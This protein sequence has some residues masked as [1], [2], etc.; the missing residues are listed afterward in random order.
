[1]KMRTYIYLFLFVLVA[2][3]AFWVTRDSGAD[4]PT[5]EAVEVKRGDVYHDVSVTGHIEPTTRMTLAFS[6]GGRL[7]NL[8][9][10]EG[11][12]VEKG[13]YIGTLDAAVSAYAVQEAEARLAVE[14]A[15]LRELLAPLRHEEK[16][17]KDASV[18]NA[19]LALEQ[20]ERTSRASLERAYV[21][22]D[23]A[24]H[25]KADELFEGKNANDPTLGVT[26]SYGSTKYFLKADSA[27]Q[28]ELNTKRKK[29]ETLLQDMK[30]RAGSTTVSVNESLLAT[31]RDLLYIQDFL[32]RLAEVVNNY[33][34]SDTSDQAVYE[35]YQASV[36][37]ARTAVSTVRGEVLVSHSA[38]ISAEATLSLALRDLELSVAGV[39]NE[40]VSAQEAMVDTARAGV[41]RASKQLGDTVLRA[42]RTGV[43]S[44]V[45]F[46]AGEIVSPYEPVAELITEGVYEV[47]AYIPEADIA[48]VKIG[49]LST[50]TFDAFERGD[51]FE[52]EVVRIAL[53]ETVKDGVPTY[54][55]TLRLTDSEMEGVQLRPG[56]TADIEIRTDIQEDVLFVP[57]RSVLRKGAQ[58]YVRVFVDGDF[59]E[60]YIET[61]LRGSEGT[62][63][64]IS[65][66]R[67]GEEIVL[68]VEE[69]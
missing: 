7:E 15:K 58:S 14:Q 43:V 20:A 42:P 32:S 51:M 26:F 50:I 56:M 52:G 5:F 38:L 27:T 46:E 21:Y 39:S 41:D 44:K 54:K 17:L 22:A 66:L 8:S 34:A 33:S 59:K 67:E 47:E 6:N 4:T 62:I 53:S 1:M 45:Y 13:T 18:I 49:D 9:I 23:D 2:G 10:D 16:A 65:G 55:T 29:I 57:V 36:T 68:Y 19:E 25:E 11:T 28:V 63:E 35:S 60:K 69:A 37:A 64:V 61:G 40:T 24:I 3:T 30:E 12:R 31:S 48:R